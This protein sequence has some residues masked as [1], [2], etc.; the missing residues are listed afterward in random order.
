MRALACLRLLNLRVWISS[1]RARRAWF[2]VLP[3]AG[4]LV[5]VAGN[6][7]ARTPDSMSVKSRSRSSSLDDGA[8]PELPPTPPPELLRLTS[9]ELARALDFDF[10]PGTLPSNDYLANIPGDGSLDNPF[11]LTAEP[12]PKS[13]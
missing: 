7:P 3:A 12:A 11:D 13:T 1:D 8:Q 5:V 2:A 9:D 10:D 4:S 6:T